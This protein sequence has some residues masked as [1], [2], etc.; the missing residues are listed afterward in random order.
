MDRNRRLSKM[1]YWL[2]GTFVIVFAGTTIYIGGIWGL[3]VYIFAEPRYWIAIGLT[4]G[5][6]ILTYIVY[7]RFLVK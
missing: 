1:R 6:T 5:L 2:F 3:G 7:K 4:A